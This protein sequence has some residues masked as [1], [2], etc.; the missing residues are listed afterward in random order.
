MR[1]IPKLLLQVLVLVMTSSCAFA[2][3]DGC[4]RR[5]VISY[6][7]REGDNFCEECIEAAGDAY[8]QMQI[9]IEIERG[10]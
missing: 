2:P 7:P 9:D 8:I 1:N 3:G 4:G 5:T 10:K 6:E